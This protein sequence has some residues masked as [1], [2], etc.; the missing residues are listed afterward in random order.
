[1]NAVDLRAEYERHSV[2]WGRWLRALSTLAVETDQRRA[3][4]LAVEVKLGAPG[5]LRARLAMVEILPF[6]MRRRVR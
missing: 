4:L 6:E 3:H 1:M 5:A 2:T